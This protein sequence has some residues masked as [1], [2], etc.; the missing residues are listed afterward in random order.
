MQP[1]GGNHHGKF[2][3]I[4]TIGKTFLVVANRNV[5]NREKGI[6]GSYKGIPIKINESLD[7]GIVGIK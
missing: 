2:I 7:D 4:F 5:N 6:I 1:T 3:N